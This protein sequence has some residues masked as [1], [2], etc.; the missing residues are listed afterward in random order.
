MFLAGGQSKGLGID[1]A[2]LA[3]RADIQQ[4]FRAADGVNKAND[5][6][7]RLALH[8]PAPTLFAGDVCWS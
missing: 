2:L 7:L 8:G 5:E 4:V 3:G 1:L 6:A